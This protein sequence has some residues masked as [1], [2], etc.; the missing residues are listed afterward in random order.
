MQVTRSSTVALIC[1]D[2]TLVLTVFPLAAAP[3]SPPL[4]VGT[5]N[6]LFIDHRF[7]ESSEM[8]TLK[9]HR[10]MLPEGAILTSQVPWE[11]GDRNFATVMEDQGIYKS[12]YL[13]MGWDPKAKRIVG[14]SVCYATSRDGIHWERP[15]LGIIEYQGS[16]ENNIVMAGVHEGGVFIDPVA[17][18]EQRYK[19]IGV[20]RPDPRWKETEGVLDQA[21]HAV[22]V[23][24][25][26]DG[27]HWKRVKEPVLPMHCDTQNQA[28]WD[29]RIQKYVVYL[30][31]WN[32]LRTVSRLEVEDITQP[33]PYDKTVK[34]FHLWGEQKLPALTTQLPV[35]VASDER[36]PAFS[37]FYNPSVI[38]YP[39]AQD[40]YFAFPS[41]YLHY[42][43]VP[44]TAHGDIHNPLQ[45]LSVAA[46]N[47]GRLDIHL[48]VSRDGINWMRPEREPFIGLGLPGSGR[49]STIYVSPS[50]I[51]KADELWLYY[52]SS[53]TTH[54]GRDLSQGFG[55]EPEGEENFSSRRFRRAVVPLHRFISATSAW[56]GGSLTTPLLVF[57]GSRLE[58]NLDTSAMGV[59]RVEILDETGKKIPGFTLQDCDPINGNLLHHTVSWNGSSDLSKLKGKPVRLCF[60]SRSTDLYA[61]RFAP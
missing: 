39:Y 9:V 61:F 1:L 4:Q 34:P 48:M 24:Y 43:N 41:A 47:D 27:I 7:I 6:Q 55:P 32:P 26:A 35:V 11:A 49:A 28:F 17:K 33:W 36:D 13:A 8:I 52:F 23:C 2:V 40:V 10:P 21:L 58:L 18:P 20:V 54:G 30:R 3:S 19:Y 22:Y 44:Q 45:E 60:V 29:A 50:L 38:H 53:D 46:G 59:A 42:D 57:S 51:R 31:S 5:K 56:E 12:W 25:S 15:S 14:Y 37:D 16:R